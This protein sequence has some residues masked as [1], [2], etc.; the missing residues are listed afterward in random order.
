MILIC[1]GGLAGLGL[2]QALRVHGIDVQVFER[3]PDV[4][5]RPQGYR[6]GI[7]EVGVEA[8]RWCLPGELFKLFEAICSDRSGLRRTTDEQ[9]AEIGGPHAFDGRAVDRRILRHL[10]LAGMDGHIRFGKVVSGFEDRGRDG[11]VVSFTDGTTAHGDLLVGADGIQSAIRRQLAP[12]ATVVDSGVRAALGRTVLDDELAGIVPGAGTLVKAAPAQL[13]L[14]AMRFATPPDQ[15]ARASGFD[16]TLPA[17]PDY[18][19]WVMLFPA[20]DGVAAEDGRSTRELVLSRVA[21][22]H[23][24]LREA[25]RRTDIGNTSLLRLQTVSLDRRWERGRV[26]L[27][28]DAAHGVAPTAGNGANTAL[29]D[30]AQLAKGLVRWRRGRI[31]LDQ[32]LDEYETAMLT[33][34]GAAVEESRRLLRAI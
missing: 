3:D 1:G 5:S 15:A 16:V 9:L 24:S 10:L 19:R 21:H 4:D 23:P 22:W 18:L 25:I 30:A 11:V 34:G 8:L 7:S 14:T 20:G 27:A 13:L 6:I 17:T 33:Y 2:A 26:T 32:A 29:R 28:G 31:T 12:E